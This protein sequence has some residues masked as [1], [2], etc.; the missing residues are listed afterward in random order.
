MVDSQQWAADASDT[1]TRFGY[2]DKHFEDMIGAYRIC[3]CLRCKERLGEGMKTAKFGDYWR[4]TED[5]DKHMHFL[6]PGT[7]TAFLFR[8]RDW[9]MF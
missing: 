4:T 2:H 9:G 8:T 1:S 5:A 6:C 3:S 7:T